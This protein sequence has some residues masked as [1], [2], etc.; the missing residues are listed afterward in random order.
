[1]KVCKKCG[2]VQNDDR[3]V[4][5]DCG[6]V[7]GKSVSDEEEHN[8]NENLSEYIDDKSERT[9]DFYVSRSDKVIGILCIIIAVVCIFIMNTAGVRLKQIKSEPLGYAVDDISITIIN[10]NL[11]MVSRPESVTKGIELL[12][13]AQV[14][15][16]IAFF[17]ALA[18]FPMFLFPR[19]IWT[20]DN[21]K[22]TLRFRNFDMEPS[23]F[24]LSMH[25]F[26]KY[27]GFA[28]V[29]IAF[30]YALYYIYNA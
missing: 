25:K 30:I 14:S 8:Y 28:V 20:L 29:I 6:S 27:L 13:N 21:L 7:L 18:T 26:M 23:D 10:S 3:S 4:C 9:E 5:I 1:M 17:T 11:T 19:L 2:A 22:Y 16:C 12:E 15:A 24:S